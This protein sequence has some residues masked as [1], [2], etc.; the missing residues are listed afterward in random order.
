MIR[1]ALPGP[2]LEDGVRFTPRFDERGLI[3]C[4]VTDA[5]DGTVLMLAHMNEEA[6]A[7]TIAERAAWFWSR[8]RKELWQKGATSG[9][10][11]EVVDLLVDC[12]QDALVM[13]VNVAGSGAACHTGRRSCFYRRLPLG[14][15]A[16]ASITTV[17]V[18]GNKR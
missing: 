7:R 12:D 2:D 18:D 16:N 1:F 13:K 5:A 10:R 17:F 4:I 11:F 9:N 8:S 15:E 14:G 3:S 6:L